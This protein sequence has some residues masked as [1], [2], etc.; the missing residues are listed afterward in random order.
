MDAIVTD[1]L[2]QTIVSYKNCTVKQDCDGSRGPWAYNAISQPG[3]NNGTVRDKE[4]ATPLSLSN[5][6]SRPSKQRE[7]VLRVKPTSVAPG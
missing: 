4:A 7:A 5:T 1:V 6:W 3:Q 2:R